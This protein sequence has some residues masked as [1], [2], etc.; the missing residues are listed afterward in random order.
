[1]F[2]KLRSQAENF[3]YFLE[4]KRCR[5]KNTVPRS[6]LFPVVWVTSRC[7]LECKMCDQWKTSPELFLKELSTKEWFMFIDSV[8]R[9]HA[10]AIVIT[11][12]EPLLR[13]DMFDIIKYIRSKGIACHVCSNG[14]LLN[15]FTVKKLEESRLNSISISL[16]SCSAEIHNKM[17]GVECFDRVI[18]GVK[19][20]RRDAPQIK[21][22]IN[23]V[24]TKLNFRGLC[25]MVPF[26]ESLGVDQIKFD[27][28]HTNLMHKQKLCTNSEGL[29]FDKS[30]INYLR[31]ELN[32]LMKAI[33]KTKLF[34]N[35]STFIRGISKLGNRG[36]LKQL[37]HA[38]YI[39]CAV[40]PFGYVSPCDGFDGKMNLRDRPFEEIWSSGSF[41]ELR[42]LATSCKSGCWDTTHAELNIRCSGLGFLKELPQIFK[43][44]RFYLD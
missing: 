43:E 8:G 16:D 14:T 17:R 23:Y 29:L 12:G 3:L 1:M 42:R 40:D 25:R 2:T 27:I 44:M 34:T 21:V 28:I 7:N 20:L 37:C 6:V 36:E 24:I 35:S 39:S 22:G 4:V 41:Q 30:D 10:L 19:F 9:T 13:E 38:G 15:K 11:G 32:N 31:Q 5:K 33:S 18:E 26:A